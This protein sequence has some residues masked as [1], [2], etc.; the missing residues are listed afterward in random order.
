MTEDAELVARIRSN[1]LAAFEELYHKYKR[2]LFHTA[3][4]IAGDH[5][6]A[7]E[8][9]Q[10]CF[11]RAYGAVDRVDATIP[12]SPWL[13]RIVVNLACNA[14]TRNRQWPLALDTLIDR[15]VAGPA[16]SPESAAQDGELREILGE[17]VAALSLKHRL[18]I[19]LY[20]YQGFSLQEIAYILTCPVG[21]VK[22]RLN[23][24]C[25]ALRHS[26][27]ADRRLKGEV[28]YAVSW[29]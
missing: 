9:L 25:V 3:L 17:A 14:A 19:I 29:K 21:T 18:V 6:A 10:D 13:H 24:A 4:A 11:V 28:A 22:S 2:P 1:D 26:L 27:G 5:G 12:L 7:E 20:Y 8:V 16:A 23:R 15:L